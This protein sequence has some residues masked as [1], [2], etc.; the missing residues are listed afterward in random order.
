MSA[1]VL[2]TTPDLPPLFISREDLV[3]KIGNKDH[4]NKDKRLKTQKLGDNSLDLR[5][6][7]LNPQ[8]S[9]QPTPLDRKPTCVT[10]H[11]RSNPN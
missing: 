6:S 7:L 10:C 8:I 1:L 3:V 4:S 9:L 5:A 11:N 2:L